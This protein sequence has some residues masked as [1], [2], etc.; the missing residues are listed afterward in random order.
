MVIYL[1][2]ISRV[3]KGTGEPVDAGEDVQ[4]DCSLT[5]KWSSFLYKG[6]AHVTV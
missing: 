1:V 4:G 6:V 5:R 2:L 3:K